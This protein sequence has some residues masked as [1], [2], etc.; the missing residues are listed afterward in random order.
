MKERDLIPKWC[1]T[2]FFKNYDIK[3]HIENLMRMKIVQ[4]Y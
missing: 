4:I 1:V 3:K 2:N